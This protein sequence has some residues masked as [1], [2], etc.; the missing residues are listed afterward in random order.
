M[1][2]DKNIVIRCKE[3]DIKAQQYIY[4]EFSPVMLGV[5]MRYLKDK[6][7]AED[8]MQEA[9]MVIFAKVGQFKDKGSFEGWM[10]R[11]M[12]NASLKHIQKNKGNYHFDIDD[13]RDEN[14]YSTHPSNDDVEI[15]FSNKKS[16]IENTE[17]SREEILSVVAEL[18]DGF[19]IVFNLYAV[20]GFK[21]KEIAENLGISISTSK[22]QL[23]RAR[24]QLQEKLYKLGIKKHKEKNNKYYSEVISSTI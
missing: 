10:K 19:R 2:V 1:T 3:G 22:T 16:V 21:H 15:N 23:I 7:L 5:C 6:M 4:E 14:V 24:K 12:I 8:I 18:P 13:V 17:F 20:E 9:F 11:I